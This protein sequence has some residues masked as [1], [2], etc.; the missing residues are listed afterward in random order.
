MPST[1]HQPARWRDLNYDVGWLPQFLTE[2]TT[3]SRVDPGL[4]G[5]ARIGPIKPA[6]AS[7]Q[8]WDIFDHVSDQAEQLALTSPP[9][10]HWTLKVF[11]VKETYLEDL[12]SKKR[13]I[14]VDV[15]S[16]VHWPAWLTCHSA[17]D[18]F[19]KKPGQFSVSIAW[20]SFKLSFF[21]F[22][23]TYQSFGRSKA[24]FCLFNSTPFLL[25]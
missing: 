20:L 2:T 21:C 24:L 13:S 7:Q 8:D 22:S 11:I 1:H 5:Q 10:F 25:T 23:I 18:V 15:V 14:A 17:V 9:S 16:M 3:M 19:Q 6:T 4:S 12:T